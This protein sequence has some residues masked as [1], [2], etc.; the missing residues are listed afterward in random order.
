[1]D[2]VPVVRLRIAD[3]FSALSLGLAVAVVG[4]SLFQNNR[5]DWH[6][7]IRELEHRLTT[8]IERVE[9]RVDRLGKNP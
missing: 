8:R 7:A 4:L 6:E 3:I 2:D 5:N 9:Y 1:M